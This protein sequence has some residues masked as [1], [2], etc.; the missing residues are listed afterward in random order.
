MQKKYWSPIMASGRLFHS[1][2]TRVTIAARY[3]KTQ[4]SEAATRTSAWAPLLRSCSLISTI[5]GGTIGCR[6]GGAV[7]ASTTS[8]ATTRYPTT[9]AECTASRVQVPHAITNLLTT[10]LLRSSC[11][12]TIRSRKAPS[13]CS[14]MRTARVL[15][16]PSSQ[17]A[18]CTRGRLT[19]G[20]T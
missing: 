12:R 7:R 10:G 20:L 11:G 5:T 14:K 6:P 8:S 9:A 15:L 4:T 1:Y 16:A 17:R 2:H 18:S 19:R 13:L 3:T